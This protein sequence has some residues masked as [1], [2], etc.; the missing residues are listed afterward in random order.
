MVPRLQDENEE[1]PLGATL[2]DDQ[3]SWVTSLSVI[4]CLVGSI[5]SALLAKLFG[6]KL[7]LLVFGVLVLIS[8]ILLAFA[9]VVHLYYLA[10]L[11]VGISTAGMFSVTP[12]FLGEISETHNRGIF[13]SSMACFYAAGQLFSYALGPYIDM[14][15]FNLICAAFP[16]S[17]VIL[18]LVFVPETPTYLSGIGK[19]VEAFKSLK[20]LRKNSTGTIQKT[21][22]EIKNDLENSKHQGSV[23]DLIYNK[24]LMKMFGIIVVL[25]LSQQLTG[26]GII[27]LYTQTIF[28]ATGSSIPAEIASIAVGVVQFT[29][30]FVPPLIVDRWGRRILLLTSCFG[31]GASYIFLGLYFYLHDYTE[32]DLGAFFWLPVVT[33]ATGLISYGI[34]LGTVPYTLMGEVFPASI[35]SYAS[36][37]ALFPIWL[38]GFILAKYFPTVVD[39]IGMGFS[40]WIFSAFGFLAVV[41]SFIFVPETKGKTFQ[42]IQDMINS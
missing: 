3:A 31:I 28:D 26:I 1:N 20:K 30:S 4:G 17:F 6:R 8:F 12:I 42:E 21:I 10:R 14:V 2:T 11:L 5:L 7:I 19:D 35:K 16:A 38:T 23:K 32:A 13:I 27:L 36:A 40:F 22:A 15:V 29:F 25:L 18:F 37:I 41:F 9:K 34:G 24:S 33:L 39:E